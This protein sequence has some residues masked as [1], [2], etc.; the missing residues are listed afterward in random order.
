M[1]ITVVKEGNLL[2]IV[3]AEGEIPEGTRLV[4]YTERERS[5]YTPLEYVQLESVFAEDEEDWGD[6]L[7]ALTLPR[8]KA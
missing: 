8:P 7:D 6:T 3:E 5:S 1:S 4:L 2:R